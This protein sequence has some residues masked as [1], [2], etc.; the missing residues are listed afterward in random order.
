MKA[1]PLRIV[2]IVSILIAALGGLVLWSYFQQ[3]ATNSLVS[4]TVQAAEVDFGAREAGRVEKVFAQEGKLL[5]PGEIILELSSDQLKAQL[6][7]ARANLLAQ[8]A[9][10]QELENGNRIDQIQ[11]ARANYEKA[12]A[13][14]A[15]SKN[16]NRTEDIASA[17]AES[18]RTLVA[19]ERAQ[20]AYQR[21]SE[22][23]TKQ[24]I[25]IDRLEE[26]ESQLHQAEQIHKEAKQ[27]YIKLKNGFR[28][29][30]KEQNYQSMIALEANYRDLVK[31]TRP[32]KLAAEKAKLDAYAAQVKEL[33]SRVAELEVISPC[34]CE[35]NDF[36]IE[37]GNLLLANQVIGTLIDL[38]H[39]WV[40]A[41]LPEEVYGLVQPG[42]LVKLRSFSYPDREFSGKIEHVALK[43]EYTPRNIQTAEGRKEQVFMVKV[44]LDN[45]KR[46][47]RPGMDLDL[48]FDYSLHKP[49]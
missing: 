23:F 34:R 40:E 12:K 14:Y 26:Y 15:L 30:E 4:G 29:E 31:G 13:A 24:L 35:L 20:K 25:P 18:N 10:L 7:T 46:L 1:P 11:S 9:Y 36:E 27:N 32:E 44:A 49:K 17:Q 19:Y 6:E 43:A 48:H 47:F 28:L 5:A 45:S 21:Q 16:G 38:D 33:K 42:D 39:L 8:Q 41:Y 2:F 22:L 3:K 37:P